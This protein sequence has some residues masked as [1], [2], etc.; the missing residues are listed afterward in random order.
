M[1]STTEGATPPSAHTDPVND[2]LIPALLIA[3]M[4]CFGWYVLSVREALYAGGNELLQYVY[5]FFVVATVLIAKIRRVRGSEARASVYLAGL[6]GAMLLFILRFSAEAGGVVGR[7][8]GMAAL[9][10]NCFAFGLAGVGIDWIS[11]D[12]TV[13][14]A[15]EETATGSWFD[16][17]PRDKRRPGRSVVVFSLVAACV[18]GAGQLALGRSSSG[19]YVRGVLFAAGY[20]TSAMLLLALT[21]L[22]GIRLYVASRRLRPPGAMIPYWIAASSVLAG[23]ALGLAWILPKSGGYA[24]HSIFASSSGEWGGGQSTRVRSAPASGFSAPD[25]DVRGMRASQEGPRGAARVAGGTGGAVEGTARGQ[26]VAADTGATTTPGGGPEQGEGEPDVSGVDPAS[27]AVREGNSLERTAGQTGGAASSDQGDPAA[28]QSRSHSQ[29]SDGTPATGPVEA[30]SSDK[31]PPTS[32]ASQQGGRQPEQ[33]RDNASPDAVDEATRR[34]NDTS[35][36]EQQPPAET[37]AA[38]EAGQEQPPKPELAPN[39]D[40]AAVARVVIWLLVALLA[41]VIL[42]QA[43]RLL[44]RL[45]GRTL[46][47]PAIALPRL[48][49]ARRGPRELENPFASR[50]ALE[51]M[52]PREVVLHTYGAFMA[53]ARVCGAP[54]PPQATA[55]EFLRSLPPNLAALK[56]EAKELSDLY[57]RAEYAPE[58]D[59]TDSLPRLSEIWTRME[60]FLAAWQR[61]A[62]Q[63]QHARGGG[64][65]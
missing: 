55:N 44:A 1:P 9:L 21:N 35:P 62:D 7:G 43:A 51:R 15:S 64:S 20:A 3:A 57:L 16:P 4:W 17:V 65:A 37:K 46:H 40:T 32:P 59:F 27:P 24:G 53:L 50:G 31:P 11:R 5:F 63:H 8:G 39:L 56:G 26:T 28:D 34:E 33:P 29:P 10:I 14:A 49:G 42:Y 41:C 25:G 45:R 38:A 6:C 52:S 47:W 2:G 23:L 36:P 13:D 30:A 48:W 58:G 19:A 18:F 60:E 22:S 12:C 61:P 54:R